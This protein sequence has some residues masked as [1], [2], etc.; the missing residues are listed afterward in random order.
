MAG[1]GIATFGEIM[2]RLAPPNFQMIGQNVSYDAI[3]G[4][5]E[6]NV[7]VSLAI[8]GDRSIYVTCL[9]DNPVGQGAVNFLRTHGVDTRFVQRS[10]SR[11]GIY[12]LEIGAAQRPSRVIYDRN[13][14]SIAEVKPGS[15]DWAAVFA[16]C[17]GFHVTGITP[18]VSANAAEE[19]LA[20]LKAARRAGAAVSIDL[21]YRKN[22]WKY[23]KTAGEVMPAL[24]E[25]ADIAIGNEEDAEK[26]FGIKAPSSDVMAGSVNADDYRFVAE[27]LVEKFPNLKKVAIT[28]R[29]SISASHNTWSGILYDAASKV[30]SAA[31]TWDMTHI[32]D[33]VGGGDAFAAGIIHSLR[34][35]ASDAEAIEFAVAASCLKHSIVGDM[36]LAT[37][38]MVNELLKSGGSGRVQR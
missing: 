17:D 26:V 36:N 33:R 13:H 16:E 11:V 34:T 8:F 14:S 15:I 28:L 29:G 22:L 18:A 30:M 7:A 21:N 25:L 12:F 20:A 2:L 23:G 38:A 37:V 4:G 6:A 3:Y 35:G 32:V 5:G 19:S 1:K 10:G 27:K 9:P 24:V 31:R